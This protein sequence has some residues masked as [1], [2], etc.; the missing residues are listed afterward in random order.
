MSSL[1]AIEP[2]F[3]QSPDYMLNPYPYW[4]RLREERPL[5]RDEQADFWMLSRYDDVVAVL[6]DD[7]TYATSPYERIFRP[8]IGPTFVEMDGREHDVRRALVAPALVGQRLERY[9]ALVERSVAALLGELRGDRFDLREKLTS[10]L[11]LRVIAEALGLSEEDHGFFYERAAAVLAGLEN[12]EPALSRGIDAHADLARHFDPVVDERIACPGEDMISAMTSAEVGGR[13][14]SREEIASHVSLLLVA[15]GET[16]DMALA[17][18]W[19]DLLTEPEAMEALRADPDLAGGAFAESMRRDGAVVYEERE[20]T[21]PVEWHGT[22][23]PAGATIRVC[24][25][26]ANHD[27]TVFRDPERFDPARPDL[28]LAKDLRGGGRGDGVAGHVTFGAG[29][30]FCLG[31]QLA[32]MEAVIATQRLLES[33]PVLRLADDADSRPV[34]HFFHRRPERLVVERPV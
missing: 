13:R 28:R 2:G 22:E 21:R 18:L 3:I 16:T 19:Y 14:L 15:G 23:I 12:A 10:H 8:V 26:A 20:T 29:R 33:M 17:N 25:G 4:R 24:L 32:R 11:P 1:A 5:Y 7:A 27:E 9:R 30:H 6:T 34:I 31:A